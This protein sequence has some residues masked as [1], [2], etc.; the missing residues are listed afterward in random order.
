MRFVCRTIT[1][2]ER[3]KLHDEVLS[4]RRIAEP[5]NYN[6]VHKYTDQRIAADAAG[7]VS[8]SRIVPISRFMALVSLFAYFYLGRDFPVPAV[9][10]QVVAAY[11]VGHI[12]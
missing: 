5:P 1:R 2:R 3:R 12:S 10:L 11:P 6:S 9:G 7:S 8:V 4:A